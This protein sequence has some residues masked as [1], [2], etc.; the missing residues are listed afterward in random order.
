MLFEDIVGVI[1]VEDAIDLLIFN[2]VWELL[3]V[4]VQSMKLYVVY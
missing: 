4:S 2:V 3:I 1:V